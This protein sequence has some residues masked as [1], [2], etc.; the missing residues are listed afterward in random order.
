MLFKPHPAVAWLQPM[1]KLTTSTPYTLACLMYPSCPASAAYSE[2]GGSSSY[3]QASRSSTSSPAP[4]PLRKPSRSRIDV[5]RAVQRRQ[6]RESMPKRV[7]G[8]A[9]RAPA[10][11]GPRR[12]PARPRSASVSSALEQ[13]FSFGLDLPRRPSHPS[14]CIRGA[15][16]MPPPCRQEAFMHYK[17]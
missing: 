12:A 14:P 13:A 6:R 4:R 15:A 16:Y 7:P 2:P 9:V 10:A 1:Q 5:A 11:E 17:V 3:S 8:K